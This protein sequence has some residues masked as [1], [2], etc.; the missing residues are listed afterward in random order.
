VEVNLHVLCSPLYVLYR[1]SDNCTLL[2]RRPTDRPTIQQTNHS[3][4]WIRIILKKLIVTQ[5]LK[6]F[7]AFCG[8]RR[9]ITVYTKSC[10]WFLSYVQFSLHSSIAFIRDNFFFFKYYQPS[11]YSAGLRA[12]WVGIPA[13]VGNLSVRHH[14]QNGLEP[15]QPPIQWAPGVLSRW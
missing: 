14:I 8:T 5:L 4:P 15:T 10:R 2:I 6:R 11:R 1:H 9:F 3:T 7:S 12:S 13:G